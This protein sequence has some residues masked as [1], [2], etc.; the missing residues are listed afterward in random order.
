MQLKLKFKHDRYN[1][2]KINRL[3]NSKICSASKCYT[4]KALNYDYQSVA[5]SIIN[6][7][8]KEMTTKDMIFVDYPQSFNPAQKTE[9][10]YITVDCYF[11]DDLNKEILDKIDKLI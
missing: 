7:F 8:R 1:D 10:H 5:H 9:N 4:I 2:W 3:K 11:K 6:L